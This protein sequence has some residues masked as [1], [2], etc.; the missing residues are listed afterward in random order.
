V[1]AIRQNLFEHGPWAKK[2]ISL[3]R[4][5]GRG[6][7]GGGGGG[8]GVGQIKWRAIPSAPKSKGI[9]QSEGQIGKPR[10]N[11]DAKFHEWGPSGT[12][13]SKREKKR[14]NDGDDG[15]ELKLPTPKGGGHQPCSQNTDLKRW[16]EERI[17]GR[18][19]T[20]RP[21]GCAKE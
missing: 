7:G 4:S 15:E 10:L 19:V 16:H 5:G 12:I 13:P 18:R 21:G 6:G 11:E 3:G 9:S 1:S 17:S 14:M 20:V 2:D 8:S